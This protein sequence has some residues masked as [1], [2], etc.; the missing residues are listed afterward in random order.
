MIRNIHGQS[1]DVGRCAECLCG[2]HST[3]NLSEWPHACDP[4]TWEEEAGRSEVNVNLVTVSQRP[5]WITGEPAW[6]TKRKHNDTWRF[7]SGLMCFLNVALEP[8]RVA[9]LCCKAVPAQTTTK[10]H[11]LVSR[12]MAAVKSKCILFEIFLL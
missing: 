9:S 1:G 10:Q 3:G 11:E 5:A 6:E 8:S 4:S 7:S 2:V 12:I